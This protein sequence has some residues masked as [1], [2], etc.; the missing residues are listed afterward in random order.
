MWGKRPT[1]VLFRDEWYGHHDFYGNR[2]GDPKEWLDWDFVLISA[3]QTI[4][5]F[6]DKNGIT[7]WDSESADM[8]ISAEKRIDKFQASIDKQ[9]KDTGKKAYKPEPGESWVP[10]VVP[11]VEGEYATY[12]GYIESLRAGFTGP[13][14]EENWGRDEY[15]PSFAEL[16]AAR[17]SNVD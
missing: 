17:E 9:T 15:G 6:T 7:V 8:I 14:S 4:E 10:K 16:Q 11:R 3:L 1:T 12:R 13:S 2:V 5:D